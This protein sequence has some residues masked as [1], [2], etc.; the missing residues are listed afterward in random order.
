MYQRDYILRMMEMLAQLI[1]GILKLI[2]TGNINQASHALENAYHFAF[3]HDSLKLRDLPE[4]KLIEN[5]LKE[6]HYTSGHLE[7]LAE[8]F[9]A[10]AQLL[11]A[12][13]RHTDSGLLYRKSL[14]LYEYIDNESRSFS[15][16]RQ[17]KMLI[18]RDRL[19]NMI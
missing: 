12:E 18:I 17:D 6:L 8:L 16:D 5:L 11:Q 14:A 3:Q 15:Q 10:E 7:M 4:E 9:L 19:A 13:E 2:K 1:A